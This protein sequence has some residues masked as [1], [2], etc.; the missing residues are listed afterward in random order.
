MSIANILYRASVTVTGGREGRAVSADN[1]L[2]L[3]LTTPS[4]LGGT[5]APG[6]NPEQLFAAGYSACFL[7]ALKLV[8]RRDKITMPADS[9][10]EGTAG[11]GQ[12]DNGYGLEIELIISLPGMARAKAETLI[13]AAHLVCPYSHAT[14]GNIDVTLTLA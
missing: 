8:G 11:I 14:R 4:E 13:A 5:G 12:A 1:T 9:S 2:N 3:T 6:S 7:A 10:I